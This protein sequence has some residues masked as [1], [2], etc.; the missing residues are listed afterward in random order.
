[1]GALQRTE[2]EVTRPAFRTRLWCALAITLFAAVTYGA[3]N[4]VSL[5][6]GVTRCLAL[7]GELD[8]PLVSWLV[9]PYMLMDG[10]LSLAPLCTASRGE[11]R[12]LMLRL[13]WGFTVG[14]IIF[15]LWPCRCGYPRVIP[16]DWTA[17]IFHLL[18]FTDLPYN[19]APSLHIVEA[20]LIAPVYLARLPHRPLRAAFLLLLL[21]GSAGT[22]LTWQHHLVDVLTGAALGLAIMGLIRQRR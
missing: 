3:T 2:G 22:V 16:D 4:A 21:L 13:F 18:H 1:M 10:L 6:R 11:L 5:S 12:T 17:P 19:Q 20:I 7:P 8:L 14:N 15:L 9:V